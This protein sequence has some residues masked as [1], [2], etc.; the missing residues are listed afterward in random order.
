MGPLQLGLPSPAM[1]LREWPLAVIDEKDCF[2]SIPLH[3]RDAA[4]FA[5]LVPSTNREAPM[6]CFHWRVLP[7]GMCN[8]LVLCQWYVAG[9]LS[10]VRKAFP[11]AVILHYM[12]D[13]LVCAPYHDY[14]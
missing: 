13:V 1:L 7:Q 3:P 11:K 10:H 5:F 8:S 6:R 14:L 4:R 12:D 2:F 9:V